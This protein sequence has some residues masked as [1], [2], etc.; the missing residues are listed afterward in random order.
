MNLKVGGEVEVASK[1][2]TCSTLC[3][4]CCTEEALSSGSC[5]SIA[6]S[7]RVQSTLYTTKTLPSLIMVL[8]CPATLK[9]CKALG[10]NTVMANEH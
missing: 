10:Y 1:E 6:S 8:F 9:D 4:C 7:Y 5:V 2:F 3:D